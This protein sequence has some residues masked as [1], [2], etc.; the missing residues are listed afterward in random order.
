M[1]LSHLQWPHDHPGQNVLF[2]KTGYKT[3]AVYL[4]NSTTYAGV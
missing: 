2:H 1:M 4:R 3:I